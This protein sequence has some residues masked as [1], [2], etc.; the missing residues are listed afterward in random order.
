MGTVA[1]EPSPWVNTVRAL[2]GPT[3]PK[4][5]VAA[6]SSRSLGPCAGI[7]L[8]SFSLAVLSKAMNADGNGAAAIPAGMKFPYWPS[9]RAGTAEAKQWFEAADP[10]LSSDQRALIANKQI[11]SLLDYEPEPLPNAIVAG[12]GISEYQ[13]SHT[14]SLR[15]K[16]VASNVVR[17]K[18]KNQALAELR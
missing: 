18:K 15:A 14:D 3:P 13:V 5:M 7:H 11:K 2:E 8:L 16:V 10:Q 4:N 17:L 6:S 9:E 12:Q 1:I